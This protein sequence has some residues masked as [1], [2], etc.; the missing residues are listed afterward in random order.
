MKTSSDCL[1]Q[2]TRCAILN[3]SLFAWKSSKV[4][5]VSCL[6]LPVSIFQ[7]ALT[8]MIPMDHFTLEMHPDHQRD[9][10]LLAW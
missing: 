4:L 6:L 9:K 8:S 5:L 7:Q 1:H 2:R 3:I 10:S